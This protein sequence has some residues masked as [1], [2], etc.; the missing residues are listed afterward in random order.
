MYMSVFTILCTEPERP[1]KSMN[2]DLTILEF[3]H[4]PQISVT[5]LEENSILFVGDSGTTQQQFLLTT[6]T[7]N[8]WK[9]RLLYD[10]T[11]LKVQLG[12]DKKVIIV[13]V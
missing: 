10:V 13:C 8:R 2:A 5:L 11:M 7:T 12:L 9:L 4:W 3:Q 1:K 6:L